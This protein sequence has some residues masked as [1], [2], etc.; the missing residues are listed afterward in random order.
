VKPDEIQ[1]SGV[2]D[3][4][5]LQQG[6]VTKQQVTDFLAQNGVKVE[7]VTL[8]ESDN[9]REQLARNQF[10]ISIDEL[11]EDQ[12]S[13]LDN[14]MEFENDE[15]PTTKFSRWQL[16]GGENYR[17]LLLTLPAK[18][19]PQESVADLAKEIAETSGDEWD[20]LG[21]NGRERYEREARGTL[22]RGMGTFRS[23]HFDQ[24]NVLAHI[25]FNE[26]TDAEGRRV[27]FLEELQGDWPQHMRKAQEAIGKAVDSDFEGIVDRMKKTGVLIVE[28]D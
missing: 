15:R 12:R 1:W 22:E 6:K 20:R 7:E 27:L 26:R 8:G 23:S 4:L 10:G 25:R 3:W 28:C 5:D 24:P 21:P 17:E 13:W 2:N 19:A 16:P 9:R 11:N 14:A 18:T